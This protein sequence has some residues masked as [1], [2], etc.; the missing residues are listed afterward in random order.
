VPGRNLSK[1]GTAYFFAFW[2]L[3]WV[4]DR[5]RAKKYTVPYTVP[6][7]ALSVVLLGADRAMAYGGPGVDVTFIGYAMSLFAWVLAALSA[8][9]MWPVYA[10]LRKLRAR[11]NKSTTPA[12]EPDKVTR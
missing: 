9:L 4:P 6:F 8:T 12:M 2:R 1:K 10:L 7:F 11:K 5:F 3:L